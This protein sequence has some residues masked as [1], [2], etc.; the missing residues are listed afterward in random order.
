M[1]QPRSLSLT[2]VVWKRSKE[3]E[4]G[5]NFLIS[6]ATG[7]RI[8]NQPTNNGTM[9]PKCNRKKLC[10]NMQLISSEKM[11]LLWAQLTAV[12]NL[13]YKIRFSS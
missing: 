4:I 5:A 12:E 8:T 11:K 7:N 13:E 10:N 9:T 2:S 6:S 3:N 1:R